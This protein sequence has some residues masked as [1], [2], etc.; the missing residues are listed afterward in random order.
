MYVMKGFILYP[1]GLKFNAEAMGSWD[2]KRY[3]IFHLKMR[4]FKLGSYRINLVT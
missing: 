1:K 3:L 2:G 4:D